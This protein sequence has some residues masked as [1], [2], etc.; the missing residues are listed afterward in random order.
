M[1]DRA[2]ESVGMRMRG[3]VDVR[4]RC[5]CVQTRMSGEKKR[6]KDNL[7]MGRGWTPTDTGMRMAA[8]ACGRGCVACGCG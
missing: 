1:C 6:K 3:C 4:M 7:L 2:D 5:V 8:L